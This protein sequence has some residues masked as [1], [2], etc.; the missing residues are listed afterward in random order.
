MSAEKMYASDREVHRTLAKWT[1]RIKAE[2]VSGSRNAALVSEQDL[3]QKVAAL[4]PRHGGCE[5]S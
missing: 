5:L 1:L 3:W 2:K 4:V